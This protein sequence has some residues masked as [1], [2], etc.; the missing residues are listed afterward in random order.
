VFGITERQT[1]VL[2]AGRIRPTDDD[3]VDLS[4]SAQRAAVEQRHGDLLDRFGVEHLDLTDTSMRA[5]EFTQ[6]VA[7]QLY[8]DGAAGVRYSSNVGDGLCWALFEGRA[9]LAPV[10]ARQELTTDVPELVETCEALGLD[11]ARL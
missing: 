3:Y 6:A 7:R 10:G 2:V 11:L 8:D 5:R 9:M 4:S 1:S